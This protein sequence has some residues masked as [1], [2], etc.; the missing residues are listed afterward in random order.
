MNSFEWFNALTPWALF[1]TILDFILLLSLDR[2]SVSTALYR[3]SFIGYA[4]TTLGWLIMK[5]GLSF[6]SLSA[7]MKITIFGWL[8]LF[9]ALF[10]VGFNAVKKLNK[11]KNKLA[12][13][14]GKILLFVAKTVGKFS[15]IAFSI[16]IA[17][18]T[19]ACKRGS[20]DLADENKYQYLN[21]LNK[22]SLGTHQAFPNDYHKNS[23]DLP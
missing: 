17:L 5:F 10:F 2:Q 9:P 16:V 19:K 21:P 7:L 3:A 14:V 8:I 11:P 20:L 22:T 18:L 15:I 1:L 12:I 4:G 23:L 13:K 6:S